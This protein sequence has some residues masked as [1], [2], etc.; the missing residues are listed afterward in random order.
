MTD[1][2]FAW[3]KPAIGGLAAGAVGMAILGFTA[4][5]WVTGGSATTMAAMAARD[6]TTAALVPVCV[7]RATEDP[8]YEATME[9]IVGESS[10]TRDDTVKEAGWATVP[11]TDSPNTRVAEACAE[12]LMKEREA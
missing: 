7:A 10:W 12:A 9:R 5:G 2:N 3:V 11:G 8:N 1:R 4:F 6:A